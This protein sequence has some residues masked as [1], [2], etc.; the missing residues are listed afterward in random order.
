[1]LGISGLNPSL[2]KDFCSEAKALF[3]SMTVQPDRYRKKLIN[4]FIIGCKHDSNWD[5]IDTLWMLAAHDRQAAK[6]NWK[7]PD[8]FALMEINPPVSFSIDTGFTGNGASTAFNTGWNPV[9]NG[10][11]FQQNDCAIGFYGRS[12]IGGSASSMGGLDGGSP[13]KG[14]QFLPRNTVNTHSLT[15]NSEGSAFGSSTDASGFRYAYRQ[16]ST[17]HKVGKN[18]SDIATSNTSSVTPV[19]VNMYLMCT[20]NNGT[21][22]R[23]SSREYA[24]FFIGSGAIDFKKMYERMYTYLSQL[25]AN[26]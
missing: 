8:A 22:Q 19:G 11:Q 26:V 20:N 9:L 16:N 1:M 23:F 10:Y 13:A 2:E 25:G 6:L 21:L 17:Q 24:M 3:R 15:L 4:S 7:K 5:K 12:S 14:V 18:G